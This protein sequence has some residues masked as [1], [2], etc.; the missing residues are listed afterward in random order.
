[1]KKSGLLICLE[2]Q[3]EDILSRVKLEGD[4][5]LLECQSPLE[6]IKDLLRE[7]DLYYKEADF[8]VDTSG[9]EIYEVV[10]KI[11]KILNNK[12]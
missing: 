11:I 12:I 8:F 2:A 9:R 1:M 7:R 6:K 3:P 5:P 4:R 10:S